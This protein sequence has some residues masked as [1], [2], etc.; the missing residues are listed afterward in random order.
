LDLFD[1]RLTLLVGKDGTG[2]RSAVARAR[3]DA[4]LAPLVAGRELT[5]QTDELDRS[6]QLGA[7]GA[8]LVR[9][10]G[11][12]AWHCEAMPADPV[13]ALTG[14]IDRATGRAASTAALAG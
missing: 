1:G 10:D 9:P 13:G 14:A 2:W 3:A 11:Y 8:V 12:V 4:P 5:D 6:Y 7:S